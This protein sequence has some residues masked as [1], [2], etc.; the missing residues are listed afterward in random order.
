MILPLD[1]QKWR[2]IPA[3]AINTSNRCRPFS[4]TWLNCLASATSIC[5]SYDHRWGDYAHYKARLVKVVEITIQNAVL[6]PYIL[7]KSEPRA[8]KLC[9]F[10]QGPLEIVD[11]IK[12]RL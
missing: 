10:A 12:T 1:D 9:I 11:V 3:L 2:D 8:N 5:A 7:Y 6:R 4:I